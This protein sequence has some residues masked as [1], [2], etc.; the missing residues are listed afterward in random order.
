MYGQELILGLHSCSNVSMHTDIQAF[1]EELCDLIGMKH[2][3]FTDWRSELDDPKDPKI[4][5]ISAVQFIRT[6]NITIHILPLLQ[7][8][9][10]YLNLFSCAYFDKDIAVKF[11]ENYFDSKESNVTMVDRR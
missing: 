11:C 9:T 2:E 7:G 6:S 4:Y 1:C 10:V 8:G 3:M 5:G